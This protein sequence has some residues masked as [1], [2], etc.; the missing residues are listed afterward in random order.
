MPVALDRAVLRPSWQAAHLL[1]VT[2]RFL[3]LRVTG[4]LENCLV[5][6]HALSGLL[7]RTS[8]CKLSEYMLTR[9]PTTDSGMGAAH[10]RKS[11]RLCCFSID[12]VEIFKCRKIRVASGR[13]WQH[14]FH[15]NPR[16]SQWRWSLSSS[17]WLL[18]ST[19][20]LLS[21]F[22]RCRTCNYL[23][24]GNSWINATSH[25]GNAGEFWRTWTLD[26]QFEREPSGAQSQHLTQLGGKQRGQSVTTGAIRHFPA[27]SNIPQYLQFQDLN[28]KKETFLLLLSFRTENILKL[29]KDQEVFICINIYSSLSNLPRNTNFLNSKTQPFRA[30]RN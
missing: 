27:T 7:S 12:G 26:P 2:C 11:P 13:H 19:R 10:L 17:A 9:F 3:P 29:K 23:E 8:L 4:I 28:R 22:K 30:T 25:S 14:G 5:G 24:N 18:L 20:F 6:R 15:Q 1:V 21:L 16:S